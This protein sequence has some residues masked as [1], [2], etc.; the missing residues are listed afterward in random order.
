ML[1]AATR[2]VSPLV[3]GATDQTNPTVTNIAAFLMTLDD[4]SIDDVTKGILTGTA[5]PP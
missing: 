1:P 5:C 4:E 2:E 3:S